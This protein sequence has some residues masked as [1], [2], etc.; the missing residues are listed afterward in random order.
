MIGGV[1]IAVGGFDGSMFLN[2][3]EAYDPGTNTWRPVAPAFTPRA[4]LAGA[5]IGNVLYA[6]GGLRDGSHVI[7]NEAYVP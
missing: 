1:L 6:V 7:G 2:T 4:N 5:A 3:A